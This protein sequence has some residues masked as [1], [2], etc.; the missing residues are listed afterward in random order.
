MGKINVIFS[1]SWWAC[2]IAVDWEVIEQLNMKCIVGEEEL[3]ENFNSP[4]VRDIYNKEYRDWGIT[5]DNKI[6]QITKHIKE[7]EEYRI[8]EEQRQKERTKQYETIRK[9]KKLIELKEE[10][11]ELK[12]TRVSNR[13]T[14]KEVELNWMAF[15]LHT[16]WYLQKNSGLNFKNVKAQ[17]NAIEVEPWLYLAHKDIIVAFKDKLA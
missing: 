10:E 11:L 12:K 15:T 3:V 1:A 8:E 17:K 6:K 9:N 2:A 4:R 14:S 16:A 5:Y 13:N 7:E